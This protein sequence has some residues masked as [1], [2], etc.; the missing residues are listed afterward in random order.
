[1][2][3]GE[4]GRYRR[5][6]RNADP[7]RRIGAEPKADEVGEPRIAAHPLESLQQRLVRDLAE[8]IVYVSLGRPAIA[9]SPMPQHRLYC[10]GD[11]APRPVCKAGRAEPRVEH[12]VERLRGGGLDDAVADTGNGEHALAAILLRDRDVPIGPRHVAAGPQCFRQP[13]H[14]RACRS[15]EH[16]LADSIPAGGAAVGPHALPAGPQA[17]YIRD[18][19]PQRH[20]SDFLV[21]RSILRGKLYRTL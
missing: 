3:I 13:L 4:Q 18:L 17:S 16:V 1:V 15:C 19:I 20:D 12:G 5:A 7:R 8:A 11:A 2:E 21:H 14:P 9:L 10:F 6:L